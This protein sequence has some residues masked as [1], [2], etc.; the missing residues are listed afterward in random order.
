[1][2]PGL[3][4]VVE[5]PLVARPFG[6]MNDFLKALVRKF[7][8][9]DRGIDLVDVGF[10]MLAMVRRERLGRN[11]RRQR[12]LSVGQ[13]RESDRHDSLRFLLQMAPNSTL[14]PAVASPS[15]GNFSFRA[16]KYHVAIAR[17]V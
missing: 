10:V 5:E 11:V 8:A 15:A 2:V 1:V 7:G 17:S 4:A 6:V 3:S 13:R 16:F 14:P 9:L 12:V